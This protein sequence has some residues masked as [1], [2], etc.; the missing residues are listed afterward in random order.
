MGMELSMCVVFFK[1]IIHRQFARFYTQVAKRKM[2]MLFV[3]GDGVI[4]VCFLFYFIF[5]FPFLSFAFVID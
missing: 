5:L 4:L 1:K 2:E 3:R